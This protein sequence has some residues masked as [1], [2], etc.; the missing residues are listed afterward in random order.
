[1]HGE[2]DTLV[3]L[4]HANI[5]SDQRQKKGTMRAHYRVHCQRTQQTHQTKTT[6]PRTAPEVAYMQ[7]VHADVSPVHQ[8][9]HRVLPPARRHQL[10]AVHVHKHAALAISSGA[11][12]V[13]VRGFHC[14][15]LVGPGAK[16]RHPE[17]VGAA[18]QAV[19]AG[20][21]V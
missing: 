10:G 15:N 14:L 17:L 18:E 9:R 7:L 11:A 12:A 21:V 13:R 2:D 3:Q 1:M 6:C 5:C 8:P 20:G 19:D 16:D 4:V